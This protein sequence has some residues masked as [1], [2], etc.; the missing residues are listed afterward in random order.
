MMR[1]SKI[2]ANVFL[3]SPLF[4]ACATESPLTAPPPTKAK[5]MPMLIRLDQPVHFT[6]PGGPPVLAAP[7][8]YLVQPMA[9]EQLRLV[10]QKGGSPLLLAADSV[11]HDI[12]LSAPIPLLLAFNEDAHNLVLLMPDGTAL[13][14]AG[15][16]SGIQRRDV[17]RPKRRY[18]L[19]YQLNPATGQIQFGEGTTGQQ[20]P[21][22]QSS[23]SSNYRRGAGA[24]GNVGVSTSAESKLDMIQ[25][26]SLISQRQL[27]I[28]LA[29]N[30]SAAMNERFHLEYNTDRPGN[31]YGQRLTT[32][33][34][35]C[36]NICSSDGNCQT[37]TFVK[38][39]SG[40]PAGL[41]SLKQTVPAPVGNACCTSAKR[42]STQEEI[43]G[44][45]K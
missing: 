24:L 19:A 9:D 4:T 31:D 13:D 6:T 28:Q 7:D 11:T 12:E 1:P 34:E 5:A 16:I 3:L 27:A 35:T 14:A 38:P 26:Q 41:C 36:R 44:N 29:T 42:K 30:I 20:P 37:L 39:S 17:V 21:G 40:T 22:L 32:S 45:L 23:A 15:S 43:I 33:A 10:P 8:D 25:L 18:Q 2:G